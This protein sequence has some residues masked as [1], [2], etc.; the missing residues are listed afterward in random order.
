MEPN[1]PNK[2]MTTSQEFGFQ[3]ALATTAAV[4]TSACR[5]SPNAHKRICQR[6]CR[7]LS[8]SS[9]HAACSTP[10]ASTRTWCCRCGFYI[11]WWCWEV[12]WALFVTCRVSGLLW[13]GRWLSCSIWRWCPPA[14][15]Q[16]GRE[17]WARG[18]CCSPATQ[19]H[20]PALKST[21]LESDRDD[22]PA[23][24][25]PHH[26]LLSQHGQNKIFPAPWR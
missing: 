4:C 6:L 19:K 15:G 14:G 8:C 1:T 7:A 23:D 2:G 18:T 21:H 17:G 16:G 9:T 25:F 12:G 26:E 13:P 11:P 10:P 5:N 3:S 22:G 24:F 20:V